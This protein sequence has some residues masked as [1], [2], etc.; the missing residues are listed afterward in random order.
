MELLRIENVIGDKLSPEQ[1]SSEI[2][3]RTSVDHVLSILRKADRTQDEYDSLLIRDGQLTFG[4]LTVGSLKYHGQTREMPLNSKEQSK[5]GESNDLNATEV[6]RC[7]F[8]RLSWPD[9]SQFEGFWYNGQAIGLGV[10]KTEKNEVFEGMWQ[11][12]KGTGMCV[13]RKTNSSDKQSGEGIEVWS[14]GSYYIGVFSEG[15]KDGSG[16]YFWT[17]GSR[18]EG[19]WLADEMSGNGTFQWADGRAYVGA[20]KNGVMHGYGVYTWQD[21]RRY[22]GNYNYN[23][24]HG[25]GTYTYSDGSRYTGEWIDGLQHGVGSIIDPDSTFERKGIWAQGK[26]KQWLTPQQSS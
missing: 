12:D 23:R 19:D 25:R 4:D 20:F 1:L 14:D 3:A 24:K 7:G 16:F 17:D 22:E 21:G 2:C 11:E 8:G 18:Y 26:L 10:F 15:I 9:N 13:F 6:V 5:Q